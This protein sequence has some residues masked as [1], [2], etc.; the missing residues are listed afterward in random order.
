MTWHAFA[1]GRG[2][3]VRVVSPM[4][5]SHARE[6]YSFTWNS[7]REFKRGSFVD[8]P[9]V[10]SGRS[11]RKKQCM[12]TLQNHFRGNITVLANARRH[13]TGRYNLRGPTDLVDWA[14]P[15]P[16]LEGGPAASGGVSGVGAGSVLYTNSDHRPRHYG[17]ERWEFVPRSPEERR[18]RAWC[19]RVEDHIPR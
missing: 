8:N 1:F 6:T 10:K 4:V 11:A 7:S 3:V 2:E 13:H 17:T 14:P 16:P 9:T 12:A 18:L 19:E 15:Y 5:V